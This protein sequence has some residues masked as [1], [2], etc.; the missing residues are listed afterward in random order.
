[1]IAEKELGMKNRQLLFSAFAAVFLSRLV[2][3]CICL[4]ADTGLST[5]EELNRW[6]NEW[7]CGIATGGYSLEPMV[8]NQHPA[9]DA[10]NW[11]FFPLF[12]LL[13]RVIACLAPANFAEASMLVNSLLFTMGLY[14]TGVYILK[15][16]KNIS[17]AL[18]FQ[19]IYAFGPYN[20]YFSVQYTESLYFLLV[21]GFFVCMRERRYILMGAMGALCSAARNTGVFLVIAI[22]VHY[23]VGYL[24]EGEHPSLYGLIAGAFRQ[25]TLIF[26]VVLIPLGLFLY[27]AFLHDLLGDGLAFIHVQRA[28]G[29]GMHNPIK[30]IVNGLLYGAAYEH[31]C[32][33][34]A[35]LWLISILKLFREKAWP[36]AACCTVYLLIPLAVRLQSIPRYMIG[37]FLPALG[38]LC[39]YEHWNRTRKILVFAVASFGGIFFSYHWVTGAGW[40]C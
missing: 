20:H 33:F 8:P 16:T 14:L 19:W 30:T 37:S 38:L 12:P 17:H 36:E 1:M 11:A 9:G 32:I 15:G 2:L 26:G 29:G 3:L 28:W 31:Y 35:G 7:Y 24:E 6:D 40:L 5:A 4:L 34:F 23:I 22:A 21:I 27:I 39:G 10:A 18:Y 13:L 25:P